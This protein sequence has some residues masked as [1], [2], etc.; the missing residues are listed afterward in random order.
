MP[1]AGLSAP[2]MPV[3]MPVP[4]QQLSMPH[5]AAHPH[6]VPAAPMPHPGMLNPQ[7]QQMAMQQM[8]MQQQQMQMAQQMAMMSNGSMFGP[9]SAMGGYGYG[10]P[11]FLGGAGGPER[12][13]SRSRSACLNCHE[14]KL[15]CVRGP[16][17]NCTNCIN[18]GQVCTRRTERRR[19]RPRTD[20]EGGLPAAGIGAM[21]AAAPFPGVTPSGFGGGLASSTTPLTGPLVIPP[22]PGGQSNP[23]A[24]MQPMQ[25]PLGGGGGSG[26]TAPASLVA[27]APQGMV[28]ATAS[29]SPAAQ[30]AFPAAFPS[31]P[32][33]LAAPGAAAEASAEASAE[34]S[35]AVAS[36]PVA[37]VGAGLVVDDGAAALVTAA[38]EA[39]APA[40]ALPEHPAQADTL[41]PQP[42]AAGPGKMEPSNDIVDDPS[43]VTQLAPEAVAVE[44]GGPVAQMGAMMEGGADARAAEQ[45]PVSEVDAGLDVVVDDEPAAEPIADVAAVGVGASGLDELD[46]GDE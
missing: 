21:G 34:V 35:V 20:L 40:Q 4:Q 28:Q 46:S 37:A 12:H 43:A 31:Q 13:P 39:D 19:G 44:V 41:H 16:D 38:P 3:Q 45:V 17:G 1:G 6:G 30:A 24:Q 26:A 9:L 29:A 14:R 33:Q 8:A 25:L 18:K 27:S 5:A 23:Q 2:L 42:W 11:S 36:E 7:A 15:R 22:G 32:G 10:F